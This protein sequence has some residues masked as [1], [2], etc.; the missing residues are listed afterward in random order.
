MES[1]C[2]IVGGGSHFLEFGLQEVQP[3][4]A[5]SQSRSELVGSQVL[6]QATG[7]GVGVSDGFGSHFLVVSLYC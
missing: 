2:L 4:L 5:P 3:S 6:L 1:P 7:G